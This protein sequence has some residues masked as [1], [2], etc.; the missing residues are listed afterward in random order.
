M[1]HMR[2]LVKK[3][4]GLP[5]PDFCVAAARNIEHKAAMATKE[6]IIL[7]VRSNYFQH[8]VWICDAAS[9]QIWGERGQ[10]S[11][12]VSMAEKIL[13]PINPSSP[14][15]RGGESRGADIFVEF[16]HNVLG[17]DDRVLVGENAPANDLVQ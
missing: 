16:S 6:E 11:D 5:E 3:L 10:L 17:L 2:S 13:V 7:F 9:Y 14:N 12:S 15:K 1:N 4:G 8:S